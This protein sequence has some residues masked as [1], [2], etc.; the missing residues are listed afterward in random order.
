MGDLTRH[1]DTIVRAAG[2]SLSQQRA[3][4]VH[5]RARSIGRGSADLK[6]QF[7]LKKLRNIALAIGILWLGASI[8]GT[9]I[10]GLGFTGVMLAGAATLGALY[11]FGKYPKMP[12]PRRADLDTEN[13]RELVAKT[14]L[15]LEMQRSK[16]PVPTAQSLSTIGAQLDA[17]QKQLEAV[18]QK[19]PT[20][21]EI[22]KLIGQDLPDMIEGFLKIPAAL[23]YEERGGTTPV[24]QLD[25]GLAVISREI[26]SITRQLAQG[27]L[28]DLAIHTRY[29]E[30]KYGDG[31]D[32]DSG[33]PLPD[34]EAGKIARS[35]I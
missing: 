22:R 28:D 17:L 16:L 30:Y 7:W 6:A 21:G 25:E 23:R 15:W 31:M 10:G 33:V 26:D 19:H 3:G 13:I 24:R 32:T 34:F 8:L 20:A 29:L 11:L 35:D 18:D 9:I 5:R 1:S 14:E 2:Q 12:V 4:G 27:S